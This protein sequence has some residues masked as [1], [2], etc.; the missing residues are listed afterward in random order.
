MLGII[1]GLSGTHICSSF[2]ISKTITSLRRSK[3]Y[4]LSSVHENRVK[5]KQNLNTPPGVSQP[6][7]MLVTTYQCLI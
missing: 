6:G 5:L 7:F 2:K 1:V 4:S 3:A